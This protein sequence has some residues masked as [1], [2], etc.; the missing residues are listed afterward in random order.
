MSY[1]TQTAAFLV[2]GSGFIW[3][4]LF[5]QNL[6]KSKEFF[7]LGQQNSNYIFTQIWFS[8]IKEFLKF[9]DILL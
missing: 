3:T 6:F 1:P 7:D 9:K 4:K 5:Q 2:G 8:T